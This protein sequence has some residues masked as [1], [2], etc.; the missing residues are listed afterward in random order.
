M[1]K[2]FSWLEKIKCNL[3]HC[4]ELAPSFLKMY[5]ITMVG[6]NIA[7]IQY[8]I[9]LKIG[10]FSMLCCFIL[11]LLSLENLYFKYVCWKNNF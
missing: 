10:H 6:S 4:L 5:N 7:K 11:N 8:L 2:T 9:H 3:N 1:P